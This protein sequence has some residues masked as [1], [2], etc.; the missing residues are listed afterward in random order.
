MKWRES[1]GNR[2]KSGHL[3]ALNSKGGSARLCR[4]PDLPCLN[5]R[6]RC[7]LLSDGAVCF[8]AMS[9]Y[10]APPGPW[11][12]IIIISSEI[13][14]KDLSAR[15]EISNGI[16]SGPPAIRNYSIYF[17]IYS[18]I[19]LFHNDKLSKT[20]KISII[21]SNFSFTFWTC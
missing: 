3:K 7:C 9:L 6:A 20:N 4:S 2:L 11:P 17:T 12:E 14:I 5:W 21:M 13:I 8:F 1:Q 10:F 18:I 16:K 15:A 19:L